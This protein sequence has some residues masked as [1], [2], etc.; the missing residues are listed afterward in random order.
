MLQGPWISS[1]KQC[2]RANKMPSNSG[3]KL[4]TVT[5]CAP[6]KS[7]A[8]K[9]KQVLIPVPLSNQPLGRYSNTPPSTFLKD[10]RSQ[11]TNWRTPRVYMKIRVY[12]GIYIIP[13]TILR[14]RWSCLML[15]KSWLR[16]KLWWIGFKPRGF[17][18]ALIKAW[19]WWNAWR[20][21]KDGSSL[22]GCCGMQK[23]SACSF[24]SRGYLSS[25]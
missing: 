13:A 4:L 12:L 21:L 11:K 1:C 14:V 15:G 17:A 18:G 9:H 2:I 3:P 16:C 23:P 6:S 5:S 24:S 22:L 10:A 25:T 7:W 8:F 20:C 19:H